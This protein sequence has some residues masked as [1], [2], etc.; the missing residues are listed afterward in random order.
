MSCAL[1]ASSACYDAIIRIP[2]ALGSWALGALF[3]AYCIGHLV[4]SLRNETDDPF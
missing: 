2:F 1:C 3:G 4:K